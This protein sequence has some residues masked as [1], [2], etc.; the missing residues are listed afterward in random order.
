MGVGSLSHLCVLYAICCLLNNP[1]CLSCPHLSFQL[2]DMTRTEG[3][4]KTDLIGDYK[5]YQYH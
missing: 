2:F 3:G 5:S 4:K 1:A